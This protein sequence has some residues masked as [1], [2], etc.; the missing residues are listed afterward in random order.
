MISLSRIYKQIPIKTDDEKIIS[1]QQIYR[2]QS[3][4]E[5]DYLSSIHGEKE[6]IIIEAKKEAKKIIE[7]ANEEY[8][9]MCKQIEQMRQE[10]EE[11]Q[12]KIREQA[13][14]SGYQEGLSKGKE[15]G[16][17]EYIGQIEEANKITEQ[18]KIVYQQEIDE[19]EK[20][21]LLIGLHVAERILAT[22]LADNVE[23]FIP[24]VKRSMKEMREFKEV[25]IHVHPNQYN[26]L[27]NHKDEIDAILH[28]G[29]KCFIYIDEDV[30]EYTC[31]IESEKGKI[32]ATISTQ[33]TEMKTR[34]LELLE[35]DE[36]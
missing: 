17:L 28:N 34:L 23:R 11:E 16:Y 4:E 3:P 10:F 33:L 5:I 24:I 29:T 31:V 30:E 6:K 18:S 26:T 1:L 19:S 32:D 7:S 9:N 8:E 21:I 14:F 27:I 36:T 13:E 15:S 22:E 25:Q 20:T 12:Q 2:E 35:S